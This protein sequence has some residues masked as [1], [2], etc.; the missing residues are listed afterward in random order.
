MTK[1]QAKHKA[2]MASWWTVLVNHVE[3][4]PSHRVT[5]PPMNTRAP[6]MACSLLSNIIDMLNTMAGYITDIPPA[7]DRFIQQQTIRPAKIKP[8]QIKYK[9]KLR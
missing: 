7:T 8:H 6:N 9:Y 4:S 5:I 1:G 2:N 3:H